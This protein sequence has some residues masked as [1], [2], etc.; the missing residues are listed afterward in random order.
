MSNPVAYSADVIV[1]GGGNA[2]LC[3]AISCREK[4]VSV[5]LLESAP[6][7]MRGGNSIHTRNMRVSHDQPND[8]LENQYTEEEYYQDL[9]KVTGGNTTK[10]LAKLTIHKSKELYNWFTHRKIYFQP[11]ISGTLN[12][13]HTNAFFLGGG[14]TL[15]NSQYEYA[16]SI[17]IT[18]LYEHTVTNVLIDSN[19]YSH[20]EYESKDGK[21]V[22]YSK[23]IILAS[24]GF[25]SNKK[26]LA[27]AW[28]E[29]AHNFLIRGTK[30][31]TGLI[32]KSLMDKNIATIGDETQCHA[33]AIDG[34]APEYD[35][36]IVTR[37]DCL[38]FGIVLNINGNRFYD[39][40]EDFWPKRYAIWG[41]LVAEQ[42][43]QKAYII[44][45]SR[46]YNLFMPS[47]FKPM[48][49][50]TIEELITMLD[51]DT[52]QA[53]HTIQEF[54]NSINKEASFNN[55]VLDNCSTTGLEVGKTNWARKIIQPPFYAYEVKTGITFTYL[56]IKVNKKTQA[57]FKDGSIPCAN[58]FVAGEMMAGNILGKG[59]LAGIGM[60]IGSVF[61][62]I[63][64]ES[65]AAYI[66]NNE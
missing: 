34:R 13:S 9:I 47:V 62:I 37:I 7:H 40:G 49:A 17:G 60:T 33:V 10:E 19:T 48:I 15:I 16:K 45:D 59:Y 63:A 54:N 23:A 58:M 22:M 21:K 29:K 14:K 1:V 52:Q 38:P 66:K 35:G 42:P 6:K 25:E 43:K 4:G 5:T 64:G 50:N 26:W 39:E 55:N 36:G 12:L 61:G 53:L 27:K 30:F 51:I 57:L 44:I 46:S 56:G 41:R 24:G 11:S 3:A 2:A 65:A 31:N 20:I 8:I 28:G 32:L 18:I